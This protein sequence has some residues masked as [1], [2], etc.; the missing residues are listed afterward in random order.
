[1]TLLL[2]PPF[3][4]AM[5]ALGVVSKSTSLAA[6]M[7]RMRFSS[8]RP[9]FAISTS[10]SF[11][12]TFFGGAD[13]APA[14]KPATFVAPALGPFHFSNEATLAVTRGNEAVLFPI[15]NRLEY[16]FENNSSLGLLF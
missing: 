2:T 11:V 16:A 1:M 6:S 15:E 13:V 7:A 9:A 4:S 12:M 14:L 10:V 8:V 5:S 3:A